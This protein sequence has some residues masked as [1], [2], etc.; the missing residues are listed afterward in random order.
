VDGA[1]RLR[2]EA[3][4][5]RLAAGDL[6][7]LDLLARSRSAASPLPADL[8]GDAERLLG[9]DGTGAAARLGL[10]E[11]TPAPALRTAVREALRRWREA[12]DDP[13]ADRSAVDA[14]E[15]V[16]RS[17][18]ALLAGLDGWSAAGTPSRGEVLAGGAGE[19][20]RR[21]EDEQH[22]GGDQR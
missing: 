17:C 20:E 6:G 4:R 2:A 7:E 10:P 19:Q 5:L 1:E 3:E 18:E 15:V 21:A 9:A 16:V 11:G 14:A 13:L 22:G 8:R 12:A